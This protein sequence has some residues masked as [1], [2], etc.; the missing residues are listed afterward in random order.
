MTI[1]NN[2]MGGGTFCLRLGSAGP[3]LNASVTNN[4]FDLSRGGGYYSADGT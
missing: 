3:V 4:F 2:Y 1:N